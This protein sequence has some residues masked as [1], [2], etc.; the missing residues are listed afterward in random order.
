VD[1]YLPHNP[2]PTALTGSSQEKFWS[3]SDRPSSSRGALKWTKESFKWLARPSIGRVFFP[4]AGTDELGVIW[5]GLRSLISKKGVYNLIFVSKPWLRSAGLGLSLGKRWETP[6]VLDMDD[7]D[8]SPD[9]YL[10]A[11][12][13][14][15]IV[16]SQE[17][18]RLFKSHSPLYLP[19]STDLEIFDPKRF[20]SRGSNECIIVW[21]GI[22]YDYIKLENLIYALSK[23]K[24]DASILFSGDGPK[25]LELIRLAKSLGVDNRVLFAEWGRRSAV[26][27]R[28]ASADIGIVYSSNTQFELC[29]CPGKLFE[30]MSMKLP[31]ITT[32]VG[33]AAATIRKA[34]CGL[35][36]PPDDPDSLASALDYL[37][38][39]PAVRRDM[40]ENG[41]NY[42]LENQNFSGLAS[43]LAEYFSRVVLRASIDSD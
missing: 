13:D 23:M 30:Y 25:K 15:I 28:L 9:S 2:Q 16:S 5:H 8:I 3:V 18:S 26:P 14:G 34:G 39:N 35:E 36:V 43:R 11:R 31:V 33:E 38:Q 41:R 20:A 12:F 37:V 42:L 27:E 6:V 7:Y 40:G 1:V 19:N 32:S 10:L 22:M 21:S 29:K 24:E 17:L 4:I